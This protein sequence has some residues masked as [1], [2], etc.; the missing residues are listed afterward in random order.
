MITATATGL[1]SVGVSWTAPAGATSYELFRTPAFAGAGHDRADDLHRQQR[2]REYDLSLSRA[3]DRRVS[4]RSPM[5]A[6]DVATTVVFQDDPLVAGT[7]I[8][9]KNHIDQLRTAINAMRAREAASPRW[10]V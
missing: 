4:N 1:T 5:S 7:T 3:G 8:V 10:R 2:R 6:P 9:K